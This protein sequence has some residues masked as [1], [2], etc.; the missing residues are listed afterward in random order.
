MQG[1]KG[2]EGDIKLPT[3]TVV[4]F[5]DW[6]VHKRLLINWIN[7]GCFVA[8]QIMKYPVVKDATTVLALSVSK[9]N[10]KSFYKSK[11]T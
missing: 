5:K 9:K 4:L 8:L 2:R 1:K 3:I 7:P 10:F 6:N 11:M